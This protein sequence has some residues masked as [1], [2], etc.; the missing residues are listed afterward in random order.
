M[1]TAVSAACINTAVSAVGRISGSMTLTLCCRSFVRNG[2]VVKNTPIAPAT[3]PCW[4]SRS[5]ARDA[6]SLTASMMPSTCM[7]GVPN[8]RE[9]RICWRVGGASSS[10]MHDVPRSSRSVFSITT[11]NC[12]RS[13]VASAASRSRTV[14]MPPLLSFSVVRLPMPQTRPTSTAPNSASSATG[15][16]L[17]K[18]H[19][20]ARYPG[21][22]PGVR[23]AVLAML[24]A[25][26]ASVLVAPK[27]TLVGRPV[28][29]RMAARIARP[30][31]TRSSRTPSKSRKLSST[32]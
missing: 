26:L 27:P 9:T 24:F 14:W 1:R 25:S 10:A 16:R 6:N 2:L 21:K 18:S 3:L 12:R 5:A 11:E 28:S 22:L 8:E 19:T 29:C 32:L 15:D 17:P 4:R 31:A 23:S 13:D 20:W 7:I 30:V